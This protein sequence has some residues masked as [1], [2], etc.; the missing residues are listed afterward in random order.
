MELLA[1][2]ICVI[3]DLFV[4]FIS[5]CKYGGLFLL[6]RYVKMCFHSCVRFWGLSISIWFRCG[7]IFNGVNVNLTLITTIVR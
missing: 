5:E 2:D 7:S 6:M 1:F 4:L 3:F